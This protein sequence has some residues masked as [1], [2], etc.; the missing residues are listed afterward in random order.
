MPINYLSFV[1]NKDETIIITDPTKNEN[2][3][4]FEK[5]K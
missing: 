5:I 3:K 4:L 2:V 1:K